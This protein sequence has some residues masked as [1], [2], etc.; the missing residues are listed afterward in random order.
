MTQFSIAQIIM[1]KLAVI[2]VH[3]K[4][5]KDTIECLDSVFKS[6]TG[7][8]IIPIVVANSSGQGFAQ[9][10]KK[11]FPDV[12][13]L[14]NKENLGV[15]GGNNM[16]IKE[17]LRRK[18]D[19][20]LILNNDTIVSPLLISKLVSYLKKS[21]NVGIISPKI[22]FAP[23]FE[24]HKDRYEKSDRGKVIWYAGGSIDWKNIYAT[25]G[26]VNKVDRGQFEKIQDTD[27]ATGC[28]MLIK[29]TVVEKVGLMDEK[30]FLYW[31]DVDYCLRTKKNGFRVLYFPSSH[32]W[33]KNA[34][35][36]QKPGSE[37]H[38]YYLTRNRL[39]FGLKYASFRTK[40]SLMIDSLRH[41]AKGG[42]VKRAVLDF[43]L[44][45]MGKG[46]L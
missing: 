1:P 24:F 42:V 16:G 14:T 11:I 32:L 26:G 22:Y 30:Y 44:G 25:H 46:S 18:C 45:R 13:V 33:H 41:F 5:R 9:K 40:K 36:S 7:S 39:Y 3:Y 34:A 17:G 27:F 8:K 28:C 6:K 2:I 23:M 15:A 35:S 37:I 4:N 21:P 38:R 19:Y 12:I 29:R 31:E 20:F 43:Y 10:I